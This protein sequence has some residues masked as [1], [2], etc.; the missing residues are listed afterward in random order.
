MLGLAHGARGAP[1]QSVPG[2]GSGGSV[3]H[4]LRHFGHGPKPS[5]SFDVTPTQTHCI[6]SGHRIRSVCAKTSRALPYS[7]EEDP[8]IANSRCKRRT[9]AMLRKRLDEAGL[10]QT[11]DPRKP[12]NRQWRLSTLLRSV[13]MGVACGAKNLQEVERLT[14]EGALSARLFLGVGARRVPDTTLRDTLCKLTPE[15]I[16]PALHRVVKAAHRRKSLSPETLPFGVA[17]LD[18]K[19][20][21]MSRALLM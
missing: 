7:I 5:P 19:S 12:C 1:P 15:S 11:E 10:C 18:G 3:S 2:L 21:G 6:P 17:S 8:T 13:V 16:T 9:L 4:L 14:E 20:T